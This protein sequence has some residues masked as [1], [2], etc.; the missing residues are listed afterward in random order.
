[1]GGRLFVVVVVFGLVICSM[2]IKV[3]FK[4]DIVMCTETKCACF[5]AF[6]CHYLPMAAICPQPNLLTCSVYMRLW[7]IGHI[8]NTIA[9][10]TWSSSNEIHSYTTQ[11]IV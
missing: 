9:I 3:I 10:L 4:V 5:L 2:I 7:L 1:M 11:H 8:A 6:L